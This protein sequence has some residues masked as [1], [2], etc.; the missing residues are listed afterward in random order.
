MSDQAS[1]SGDM[2]SKPYEARDVAAAIRA[3]V[4]GI[5][6]KKLHKLLYYA[7][8]HH[9]SAFGTPLFAQSISAWD[10]GPVVGSLWYEE[11][12]QDAHADT[13]A[14]DQAS[15]NTVGYV[16]SRYGRL[17]GRDLEILSHGEPPWQ[18]TDARRKATGESSVRL[19]PSVMVGYF[20]DDSDEEEFAVDQQQLAELLAGA[21]QR[22]ANSGAEQPDDLDRLQRRIADW[23]KSA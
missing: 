12:S 18:D 1:Y 4:P 22:A 17:T 16:V 2:P 23:R 7:Q 10:M 8:G 19:D 11:K 6:V 14:L 15:L 21:Q 5:G 3:R 9:L 13:V 20:A